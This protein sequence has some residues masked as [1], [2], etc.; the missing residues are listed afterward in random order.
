MKQ[1]I[2]NSVLLVLVIAS[3]E[4]RDN[5]VSSKEPNPLTDVIVFGHFDSFIKNPDVLFKLENNTLYTTKMQE[6]IDVQN[7]PTFYTMSV[8]D[9][10]VSAATS[11]LKNPPSTL[12]SSTSHQIGFNNPDVGFS[13]FQV[14]SYQN[15]KYW[16]IAAGGNL[17]SDQL[18]FA[19]SLVQLETVLIKKIK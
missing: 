7:P 2:L 18:Q 19:T 1:P 13:Y 4:T 3:C 14:G 10:I 15:G 9:S 5:E 12:L 17:T 6:N 8:N 16:H 11:I